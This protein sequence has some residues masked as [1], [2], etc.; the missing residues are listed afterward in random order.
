MISKQVGPALKAAGFKR[1]SG[2]FRL[3][4]GDGDAI[5]LEFQGSG[6]SGGDLSLFYLNMAASTGGFLR[7]QATRGFVEAPR[8]P[9]TMP[10]QWWNRLDAAPDFVDAVVPGFPIGRDTWRLT[11]P[12]AAKRCGDLLA[13]ALPARILPQIEKILDH[14]RQIDDALRAGQVVLPP[15]PS[16]ALGGFHFVK[17]PDH[18]YLAWALSES[19]G[20][21][22]G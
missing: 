15:P 21:H 6:S 7:W 18:P 1:S 4:S 3:R 2:T 12:K 19:G 14:Y 8:L 9:R 11:S 17:K 16:T 13:A 5:V 20:S 22:G 10:S